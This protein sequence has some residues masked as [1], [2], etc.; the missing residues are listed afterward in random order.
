MGA[1]ICA[2]PSQQ[3]ARFE[4]EPEVQGFIGRLRHA[5]D[6][7]AEPAHA[8]RR[9]GQ[10]P[11]RDRANNADTSL[12]ADAYAMTIRGGHEEPVRRELIELPEERRARPRISEQKGR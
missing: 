9:H 4:Q 10:S 1:E 12:C 7:R 6:C 3:T 5:V 8:A 11:G 2:L